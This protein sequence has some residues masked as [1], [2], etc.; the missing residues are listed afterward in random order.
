MKM[1]LFLELTTPVMPYLLWTRLIIIVFI[2]FLM[3]SFGENKN[4]GSNTSDA[5]PY[6]F[7]PFWNLRAVEWE[8]KI[9]TILQFLCTLTILQIMQQFIFVFQLPYFSFQINYR[10]LELK[11]PLG[12]SRFRN[13]VRYNNFSTLILK[14]WYILHGFYIW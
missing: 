7:V 6:K 4:A 3:V 5:L 13:L 8:D 12:M 1:I 10:V 11:F 9:F 2:P 14:T